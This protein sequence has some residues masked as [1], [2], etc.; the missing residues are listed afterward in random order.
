M[1]RFCAEGKE[2]WVFVIL[3]ISKKTKVVQLVL[4]L[5]AVGLQ[6]VPFKSADE[7]SVVLDY[8]FRERPSAPKAIHSSTRSPSGSSVLPF[9]T[10]KISFHKLNGEKMRMRIT[11]N[12]PQWRIRSRRVT[13]DETYSL[14]LGYIADMVDRV[15]P[16]EYTITL[17]DN[18]NRPA[19][20]I[21]FR[22]DDDG[23]F[24]V[25]DEKRGRF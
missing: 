20:R 25:N 6:D 17:I 19:E 2:R 14:V 24:Y 11:A 22:V 7:F 3:R 23:S 13:P 10:L 12:H 9:V 18:D 4:I 5:I 21:V 1:K 15:A 16:Y 8:E